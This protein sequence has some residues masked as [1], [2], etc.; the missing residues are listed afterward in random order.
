MKLWIDY[1][2]APSSNE[3]VWVKSLGRAIA[4]II[5]M[6]NFVYIGENN[7]LEEISIYDNPEDIMSLLYYFSKHNIECPILIHEG[8][9]NV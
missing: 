8:E 3:W 5:N 2:V 6:E 4:E 9:E 1:E 7:S